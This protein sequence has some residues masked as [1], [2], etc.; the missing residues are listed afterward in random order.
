MSQA[1]LA[2]AAPGGGVDVGPDRDVG[3]NHD[4]G[5][6]RGVALR[7]GETRAWPAVLHLSTG[8]AIGMV[9]VPVLITL[10]LMCASLVITLVGA[11]FVFAVLVVATKILAAVHRSRFRALLGLHISPPPRLERE[12]GVIAWFVATSRHGAFWRAL[13]HGL[14]V[15]VVEVASGLAFAALTTWAAVAVTALAHG[16]APFGPL[17]IGSALQTDLWA[18]AL[19]VLAVRALPCLARALAWADAAL[20][21]PLLGRSRV[22][23][24]GRR[25][26]R[27]QESRSEVLDAADAERRRIERDLHDGAQQ[28]LTSLAMNLGIAKATLTDLPEPARRALDDAHLEAKAAL[29]EL[30]ATVRGL[31]PAVLDDRGLDAALSGLAGRSPVPVDLTVELP[32]RP[33]RTVE[34][35][36]YFVVSESLTNVVKHSGASRVRVSVTQ[37]PAAGSAVAR[38][39]VRVV[40]DGVGGADPTR[41]TGLL[42]LR[43]RVASVDGTLTI[44][45]PSG[46]PT[47]LEAVLPCG[48]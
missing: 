15:G 3:P 33:P 22:D 28:R 13:V 10:V 26:V 41:G 2:P 48:S 23:D 40:D 25:V 47:M 43:Q 31:H 14:F 36:A 19:G 4:I 8:T 9:S 45:S 1:N 12:R 21:V 27:L 32:S 29:T 11:V 44:E 38:L 18:T 6:H 30:R 16:A 7:F 35:I 5:P 46:G 42:G 24:L 20:T 37:S 17:T 34:A 39:H